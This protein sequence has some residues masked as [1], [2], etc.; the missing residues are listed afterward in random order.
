[1]AP[2]IAERGPKETS[3]LLSQALINENNARDDVAHDDPATSAPDLQD[4]GQQLPTTAECFSMA[5]RLVYSVLYMIWP[6]CCT[7]S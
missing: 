4:Q 3:P 2:E 5:L 7:L 1:M 6:A